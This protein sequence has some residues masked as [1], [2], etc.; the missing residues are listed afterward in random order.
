MNY[1]CIN[2]SSGD[3]LISL[4]KEKTEVSALQSQARTSSAGEIFNKIEELLTAQGI[5]YQKLN[6]LVVYSGPGSFTGLRISHT[7]FNTLAYAL[8]IPVVST[9]G[10]DWISQGISK[11][12]NNT[13]DK[14]A[15]PI[16]G[17]QANITVPKK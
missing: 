11:I 13:Y 17:G 16:Y 6:G 10:D 4:W 8:Q 15:L 9:G 14:I 3:C 1:V 5:T 12:T 2:S 7:V